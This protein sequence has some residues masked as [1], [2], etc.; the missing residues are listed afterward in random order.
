MDN[1]LII[2]R[3]KNAGVSFA[4]G[5]SSDEFTTIESTFGFRFPVEIRDFLACFLP[6]GDRFFNWR[7]F[8][9]TNI[10]KFWNN[11]QAHEK[12]FLFDIENNFDDLRDLLGDRFSG[13]TDKKVFTEAVLNYLNQSARL[14]PFY[15][16]RCFFDGMDHM[17]IVS[18]LQPV[19]VIL[20]GE[21]FEDYLEVEFL[22]KKCCLDHI[23]EQMKQT[24]I[25]Y[26]LI[27]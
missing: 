3:L 13:I 7:D 26:D 5:L 24:G 16:H 18:F 8:S 6:A 22:G 1:S 17:P 20:Y 10:E 11:L 21:N 4:P 25:W 12:A 19:D 15:A 23:P 9:D 2:A 14:I 27:C